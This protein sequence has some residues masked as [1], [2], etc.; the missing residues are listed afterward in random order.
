MKKF[1]KESFEDV[2]NKIHA[3]KAKGPWVI[4]LDKFNAPFFKKLMTAWA[5]DR[6]LK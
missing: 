4:M 5:K 3:A 6:N 2:M 1:E